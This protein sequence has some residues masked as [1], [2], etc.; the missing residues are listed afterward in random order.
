[1]TEKEVRGSRIKIIEYIDFDKRM[2]LPIH[3]VTSIST[4]IM[5]LF[6]CH[7]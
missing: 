3:Y 7:L 2:S 6:C 1:M 4:P 5:M